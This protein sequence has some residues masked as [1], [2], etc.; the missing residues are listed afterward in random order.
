MEMGNFTDRGIHFICVLVSKP[1]EWQTCDREFVLK[2]LDVY[3]SLQPVDVKQ[4]SIKTELD[5]QTTTPHE[6]LM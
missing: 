3:E 5:S 1:S 6:I 4:T 2:L